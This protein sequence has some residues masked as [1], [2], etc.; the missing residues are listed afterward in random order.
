MLQYLQPPPPPPPSSSSSSS[1][2]SAPASSSGSTPLLIQ[3]EFVLIYINCSVAFSDGDL[4]F[5]INQI[6]IIYEITEK[7]LE[8]GSRVN[9]QVSL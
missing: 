4:T 2:S 7:Q 6:V 5:Y 3:G 1:S 8:K 9:F